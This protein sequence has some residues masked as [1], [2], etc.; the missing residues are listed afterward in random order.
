MVTKSDVAMKSKVVMKSKVAMKSL[1][2]VLS[3]GSSGPG[4]RVWSWS[5]GVRGKVGQGF[6]KW[7]AALTRLLHLV[8]SDRWRA[9][10]RAWQ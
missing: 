2:Y 3:Q 4:I 7:V 10:H 8:F 6:S 5:S 9:C 1:C